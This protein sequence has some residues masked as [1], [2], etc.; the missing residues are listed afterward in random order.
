MPANMMPANN[1][2]EQQQQQ[3][4]MR[5]EVAAE[6]ALKRQQRLNSSQPEAA[7][8][9]NSI[10]SVSNLTNTDLFM[11]GWQKDNIF[12]ELVG[13][14][15]FTHRGPTPKHGWDRTDC[16]VQIGREGEKETISIFSWKNYSDRLQEAKLHDIV[17]FKNLLVV[18]ETGPRQQWTGTVDIKFKFIASSKIEIIQRQQNNSIET[19][20]SSSAVI[21]ASQ[22]GSGPAQDEEEDDVAYVG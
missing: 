16:H 22:T 11:I 15:I 18:P 10:D 2:N 3:S 19:G 17:K 8:F 5:L 14:V 6:I 20:P 9:I 4:Q 12:P 1:I 7:R 13:E 21:Y